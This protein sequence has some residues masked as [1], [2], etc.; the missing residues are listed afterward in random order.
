MDDYFP[1][2]GECYVLYLVEAISVRDELH[3]YY[4]LCMSI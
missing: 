3:R 4:S 1:D 2:S